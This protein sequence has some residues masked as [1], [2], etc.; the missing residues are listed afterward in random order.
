MNKLG[1]IVDLSHSHD[2]TFWDALRVSSAPVIASHSCC[3]ALSDHHRNLS[4]EM[5]KALAKNG[6]VMGLNFSAGFLNA[7]HEEKRQSLWEEIARELGLPVDFYEAA[8]VN[9]EMAS[10]AEA[11][12][13]ARWP[14]VRSGLP[15]VD[16]TT[17][18]DHIDHVVKVTG[19]ADHVGLGSDF[20]GM[21]DPP[22]GLED[23]GRL[24]AVTDELQRRGYK[25]ADIR[26]ILG[27]NFL[28][29]FQAVEKAAK[30]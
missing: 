15:P 1:M 3:R 20:D 5:L 2:E 22:A 9:P 4:D 21:S 6:G 18:V 27:G 24:S 28:R 7:L 10:K 11:E 17:V 12:F 16:V 29:V 19:D 25:E 26:K 8:K 14:A 30:R 13:E 23:A